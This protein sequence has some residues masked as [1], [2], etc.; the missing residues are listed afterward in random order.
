MTVRPRSAHHGPG[1]RR[2]RQNSTWL[3]DL[4]NLELTLHER[5]AYKH[6]RPSF[7][8]AEPDLRLFKGTSAMR[9]LIPQS[10]LVMVLFPVGAGLADELDDE[11]D[12][13]L[14]T[15]TCVR[16]LEKC[17]AGVRLAGC[18]PKT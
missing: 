17:G 7:R 8:R 1:H 10:L 15:S 16:M 2:A 11:P 4:E 13:H 6:L 3:A 14:S 12:G 9:S 5:I 18:S